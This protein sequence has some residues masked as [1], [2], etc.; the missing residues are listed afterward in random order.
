MLG[1]PSLKGFSLLECD[2]VVY[3]NVFAYISLNDCQRLINKDRYGKL[4]KN[5]LK[6]TMF[7]GIK[8][9]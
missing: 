5:A 3:L 1:L 6:V 8:L 9:S 2:I 4:K 7:D